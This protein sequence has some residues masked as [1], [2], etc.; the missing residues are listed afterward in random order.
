MNVIKKNYMHE[1]TEVLYTLDDLTI[2]DYSDI[3]HFKKLS[4]VNIRKRV[5]LCAHLEQANLLHEMI[6]VHGKGAYVRPHKH[7]GKC[8]S[9]H[10]VEGEVDVV[11]FDNEGR[12]D[13]VIKMGEYTSGK[14]F[15]Y[16]MAIPTYHTFII[17]SEI[18]VFHE[19]TNGPFNKD[20]IIFAPWA[21][22]NDDMKSV[23]LFMSDLEERVSLII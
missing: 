13:Q 11:L 17:R 9:T 8:E 7:L 19:T 21:P 12:I 20:S 10:I 22:E 1:N 6:I 5:R 2:T 15:F 4:K 16:R 3:S 18:L 23:E 14:P